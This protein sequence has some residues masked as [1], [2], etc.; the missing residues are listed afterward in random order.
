MWTHY[1]SIALFAVLT[2]RPG[3]NRPPQI[4]PRA[5]CMLVGRR[6]F[7]STA[8][9]YGT[10]SGPSSKKKYVGHKTS[11][12][13]AIAKARLDDRRD[14]KYSGKPTEM[15]ATAAITGVIVAAG[16]DVTVAVA[17]RT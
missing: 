14:S 3:L 16:S 4:Q 1:L 10:N 6:S 17:S 8:I 2:S 5:T 9:C 13:S 15:T 7:P 11:E 12:Q